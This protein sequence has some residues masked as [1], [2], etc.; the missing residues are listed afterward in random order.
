M[1]TLFLFSHCGKLFSL[2][3]FNGCALNHPF[4]MSSIV[5]A[6]AVVVLGA[7][8]FCYFKKR[9]QISKEMADADRK[10]KM[11]LKEKD[12]ENE[13]FWSEERKKVKDD[14]LT[15]KIREYDELTIRQKILDKVIEAKKDDEIKDIKKALDELKKKYE[16][17]DGEIEQIIIKKK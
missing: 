13:K 8:V 11:E 10:L 17:L 4:V 15:R 14:E 12:L 16:S 7:L 9:V 5:W 6:I 3:L 1:N 2:P